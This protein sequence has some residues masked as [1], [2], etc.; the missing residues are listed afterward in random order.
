MSK[1]NLNHLDDLIKSLVNESVKEAYGQVLVPSAEEEATQDVVSQ[2]IDALH[3][4]APKDKK[5][6]DIDDDMDEEEEVEKV[7][8]SVDAETEKENKPKVQFTKE[9]PDVIEVEQ[10]IEILNLIR[11]G[12]SLKD[13]GV[14][15]RFTEYFGSLPSPEKIALLGFLDGLSQVIVGGVAGTKAQEPGQPPFNVK[16]DAKP[17]QETAEQ[18]LKKAEPAARS[19]SSKVPSGTQAPIIVGEVADKTFVLNKL[20]A[21]R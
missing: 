8:V 14:L 9:V 5:K 13:E 19:R 15:E 6:K 2:E 17:E 10:V 21:L 4:R 20:K 11:S 12:P 7:K 18:P 1:V 16:M 3:L